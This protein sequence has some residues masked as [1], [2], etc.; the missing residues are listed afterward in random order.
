MTGSG[1]IHRSL[2]DKEAGYAFGSIPPYEFYCKS[3]YM[4]SEA[5][6]AEG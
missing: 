4:P 5:I 3:M 2:M 6:L 1:V